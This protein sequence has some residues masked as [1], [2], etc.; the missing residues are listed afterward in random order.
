MPS[1]DVIIRVRDVR[2]EH[3]EQVV[4]HDVSFDIASKAIVG[5][6]G[7]N[8]AG[9][10]TLAKIILGLDTHYSGSVVIKEKLR[11]AYVPQ[12]NSADIYSLPLSVHEFMHSAANTYYGRA[13]S[14][15]KQSMVKTLKHV[16][17][18]EHYL[19]QNFYTLSG[20]ERQRVLIA[21]A[22]LSNPDFIVLDEPLASVD[23]AARGALYELLKHLNNEHGFTLLLISH[24]VEGVLAISDSVLCLNKTLFH[25]CHPNDFVRNGGHGHPIGHTCNT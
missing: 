2:K 11:I 9:K 20:G 15:D 6:I 16:G 24:D 12:F 18:D 25:G 21:R 3:G 4:L 10:T 23:Y 5:I 22:L 13:E 8:G 1:N 17:L 7:P 14:A 19:A